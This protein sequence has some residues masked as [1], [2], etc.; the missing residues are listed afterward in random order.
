MFGELARIYPKLNRAPRWLRA[1]STLSEISLDSALGY[2]STLC[3]FHDDE[4]R[5]LFAPQLLTA[6]DGH[7]PS[8]RIAQLMSSDFSESACS[9]PVFAAAMRWSG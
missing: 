7:D 2:Y 5:R 1:K 8:R 3:K 4:R 6:I 9:I